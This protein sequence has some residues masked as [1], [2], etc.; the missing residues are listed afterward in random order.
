MRG[1]FHLTEIQMNSLTLSSS[2]RIQVF[3]MSSALGIPKSEMRTYGV[4]TTYGVLK[5]GGVLKI[6]CVLKTC[7][8]VKSLDLNTRDSAEMFREDLAFEA[9]PW[10][11][12]VISAV[13]VV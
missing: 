13:K 4:L 1:L 6:C 8:V 12:T 11:G 5:T 9:A 2:Q 10:A 3:L 7:D